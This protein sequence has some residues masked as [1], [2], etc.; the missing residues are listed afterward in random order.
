M[1]PGTLRSQFGT[2]QAQGTG[3]DALPDVRHRCTPLRRPG[4][5]LATDTSIFVSFPCA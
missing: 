1:L 5:F 2:F 3:T 4:A